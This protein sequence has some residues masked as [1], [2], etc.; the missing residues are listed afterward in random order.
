VRYRYGARGAAEELRKFGER[1]RLLVIKAT[2]RMTLPQ[3]LRDRGDCLRIRRRELAQID[4]F[5]VQRGR[6]AGS[7]ARATAWGY[8][9]PSGLACGPS[10]LRVWNRR[11]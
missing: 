2:G 5:P 11:S 1:D 6:T 8:S 3:E 4:F 10:V 7:G 9:P